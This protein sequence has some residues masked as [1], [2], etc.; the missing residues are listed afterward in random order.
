[1]KSLIRPGSQAA[2]RSDSSVRAFWTLPATMKLLGKNPATGGP[3][4]GL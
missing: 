4:T 2:I 3:D 1:M